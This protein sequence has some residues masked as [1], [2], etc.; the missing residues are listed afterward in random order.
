MLS[1]SEKKL[2]LTI[3]RSSI[4]GAVQDTEYSLPADVTTSLKEPC[5]A[6]VTLHK[7]GDLR[8]CIGYIEGVEPLAET[9][10]DAAQKAAMEDYRFTPVTAEE[11]RELDIEISVLSPLKLIRDVKEIEVGKHGILLDYQHARGLLL[12]Q[13][14]VEYSWDRETFL[15]QTARKAGLSSDRWKSPGAKIYIFTAEIFSE[16]SLQ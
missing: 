13:V 7:H 15:N 1:E 8:G 11:I 5:G 6:F 4:E 9:V 16:H 3:A 10:R 2:L 14:A 12:P